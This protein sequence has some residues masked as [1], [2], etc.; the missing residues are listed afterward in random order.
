MYI[1]TTDKQ[2]QNLFING[3]QSGSMCLNDTI[4]QYSG[5]NTQEFNSIAECIYIFYM[6]Y[7]LLGVH[8]LVTGCLST[9][10]L[11][12]PNI[13]TYLHNHYFNVILVLVQIIYILC[14]RL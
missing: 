8:I 9:H 11:F 4:M 6:Y 13:K 12:I 1:F 10:L 14:G 5:K 7:I 2:I 3:T